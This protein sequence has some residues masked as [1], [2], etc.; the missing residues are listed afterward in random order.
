MAWLYFLKKK[1]EVFEK[2]QELKTLVE[3]QIDKKIK[4]LRNDNGG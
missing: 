1:S 3:N 4:A 2:F